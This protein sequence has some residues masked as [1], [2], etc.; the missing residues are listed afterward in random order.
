MAPPPQDL[1]HPQVLWEDVEE[2]ID[3]AEEGC[4]DDKSEDMEKFLM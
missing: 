3:E 2:F 4:E 1:L